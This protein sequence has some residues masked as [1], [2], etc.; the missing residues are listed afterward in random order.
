MVER[1]R[2]PLAARIIIP[3]SIL[4]A[5]LAAG[6][7][8]DAYRTA[9]RD[10]EDHLKRILAEKERILEEVKDLSKENLKLALAIA[11]IPGVQEAVGLEDR[12]R[13]IGIIN[14][15]LKKIQK[16]SP[17]PLKVHFHLPPGK[18][19]LRVWKPEKWGDDLRSFRKTVVTVLNTGKPVYGIE[20]GRAGLAVRG[21]AP[22]SGRAVKNP[23]EAWKSLPISRKWPSNCVE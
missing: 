11:S 18:S 5:I 15:F 22:Y 6:M 21:V 9:A 16:E 13:L 19:F 4:F 2:L 20:P 10:K 23:W 3:L 14:P 17:Y 12:E 7:V 8:W 1:C